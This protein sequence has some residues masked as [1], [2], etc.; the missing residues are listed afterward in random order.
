M[1]EWLY[2]VKNC[3]IDTFY[4]HLSRAIEKSTKFY[5]H[6]ETYCYAWI[7]FNRQPELWKCSELRNHLAHFTLTSAWNN[8]SKHM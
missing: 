2:I 1:S 3:T 5:L 8:A 4:L 6:P 7:S